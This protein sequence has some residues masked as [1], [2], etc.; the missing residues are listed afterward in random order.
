M[1]SARNIHFEMT[2]RDRAVNYGGIGAIHLMG[3]RLRLA[4]EID[5]RL[6]LLKRHLPYHGVIMC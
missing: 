4:E 6:K 3:Q 2:E 1:L 5:G